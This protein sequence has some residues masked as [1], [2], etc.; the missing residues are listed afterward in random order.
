MADSTAFDNFFTGVMG[1]G[2]PMTQQPVFSPE[3]EKYLEGIDPNLKALMYL[4]Q[5]QQAIQNDPQRWR[6][7]YQVVKEYRLEEAQNAAK[8]QAERDKRAFQYQ[9]LANIPKT[10]T[11]TSANLAQMALNAPDLRIRAQIPALIQSAWGAFPD[12]PSA[13]RRTFS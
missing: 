5:K 10:I 2:N 12:V 4:N 1:M 13:R 3:E 7:Q 8:I 11:E 6:E 9:M